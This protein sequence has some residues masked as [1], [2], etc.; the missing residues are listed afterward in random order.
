LDEIAVFVIAPLAGSQLF[1]T[2]AVTL[3]NTK[4]LISFSPRGRANYRQLQA[5][6][7]ALIKIF[8]IE[9]LKRGLALW[10]QGFRALLGTPQTKMENLP[11][12]V[13]WIYWQLCKIKR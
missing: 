4:K 1:K 12:R 2:Q 8:F 6:R 3:E 13:L 9:K 5:F 10:Q 7:S 11:K